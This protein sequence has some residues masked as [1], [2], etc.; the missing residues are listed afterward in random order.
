MYKTLT[1]IY[2]T[3]EGQLSLEPTERYLS[4]DLEF[5]LRMI[6]DNLYFVID[7]VPIIG[8]IDEGTFLNLVTMESIKNIE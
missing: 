6:K 4:K 1:E 8:P 5:E 7:D 3:K 2:V